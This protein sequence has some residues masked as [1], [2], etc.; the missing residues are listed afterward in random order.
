MRLNIKQVEAFYR[1]FVTGS[2]TAA[3]QQLFVSQP[4]V[5]R[6][7][8]DLEL[9]VN[10]KLF[11][12]KNRRLLPT[13]EGR[14][15]F[16]EIEKT[17]VGLDRISSRADEIRSFRSGSVRIAA[18]PAIAYSVLPSVIREFTS[19]HPGINVSLN[20]L[21]SESVFDW[22]SAQQ[23]DIGIAALTSQKTLAQIE[24]IPCPPCSC[25]VP[26][27]SDLAHKAYITPQDLKDS[28]FISLL[29]S[30]MLRRRIDEV[31]QSAGISRQMAL[32][33]TYSLSAIQLVKLGLGATIV[34]PFSAHALTDQ[35]IAVKQFMP[36]I[37]YEFG[38]LFP[39]STALSLAAQTF[40]DMLKKRIEE[41]AVGGQDPLISSSNPLSRF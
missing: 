24:L 8:A 14:M 23:M 31:F 34:D 27:D 41:L 26:A 10:L 5:S 6:L 17:F 13:A 37:P 38:L 25:V 3:A 32:E 20:I 22:L 33:T 7:V 11:E 35:T 21:N 29:A 30:S 4:A 28:P 15:L 9:A 18:M 1:V 19:K 2:V 16:E 39:K 12:R 40:L 36:P